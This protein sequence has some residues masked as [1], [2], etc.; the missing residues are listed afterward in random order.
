[1]TDRQARELA[2]LKTLPKPPK[3]MHRCTD[4]EVRSWLEACADVSAEGLRTAFAA[5]LFPGSL[6]QRTDLWGFYHTLANETQ[7]KETAEQ[8][9]VAEERRAKAV[10]ADRARLKKLGWLQG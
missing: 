4:Q 6:R 1:M 10:E 5:H 8:A 9:K 2:I 3:Q 7:A